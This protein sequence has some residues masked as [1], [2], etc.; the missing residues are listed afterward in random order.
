MTNAPLDQ[1]GW[2][3]ETVPSPLVTVGTYDPGEGWHTRGIIQ[4]QTVPLANAGRE[5]ETYDP[6][7]DDFQGL[8]LT[9][10]DYVVPTIPRLPRYAYPIGE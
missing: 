8:F 4:E 9:P 6:I 1:M 7:P 3:V 10:L 5:M 2:D